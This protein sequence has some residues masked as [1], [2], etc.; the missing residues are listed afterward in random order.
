MFLVPLSNTNVGLLMMTDD[1]DVR[2]TPVLMTYIEGLG[3]LLAL[4][5]VSVVRRYM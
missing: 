2:I 4:V 1:D 3:L 5:L